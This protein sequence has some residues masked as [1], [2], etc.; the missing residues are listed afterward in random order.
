M[1]VP[2]L[3]LYQVKRIIDSTRKRSQMIRKK[4]K[5]LKLQN[6]ELTHFIPC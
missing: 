4:E 1:Q 2:S 5:M 3:L 6:Q